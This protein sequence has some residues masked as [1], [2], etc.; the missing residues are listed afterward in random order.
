LFVNAARFGVWQ[1]SWLLE[2]KK[3]R[4]RGRLWLPTRT[5]WRLY[6][7]LYALRSLILQAFLEF[8]TD[9]FE[10]ALLV[11]MSY[12]LFARSQEVTHEVKAVIL[13][14]ISI[15]FSPSAYSHFAI[16]YEFPPTALHA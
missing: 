11:C 13:S 8:S 16:D 6:F 12:L 10:I 4:D 3:S 2:L 5:K 14:S 7:S 15:N 9:F 1:Q